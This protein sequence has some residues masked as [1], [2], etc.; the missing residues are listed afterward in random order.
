[1]IF[2]NSP[3]E[4]SFWSGLNGV[5][6]IE[7]ESKVKNKT[8]LSFVDGNFDGLSDS[9]SSSPKQKTPEKRNTKR[10]VRTPTRRYQPLQI[11]IKKSP[12]SKIKNEN[13]KQDD[14]SKLFKQLQ[15]NAAKIIQSVNKNLDNS[16]DFS[17][18]ESRH[19][20]IVVQPNEKDSTTP[21]VFVNMNTPEKVMIKNLQTSSNKYQPLPINVLRS[22]TLNDKS[23]SEVSGTKSTLENDSKLFKPIQKDA[24]K[25]IEVSSKLTDKSCELTVFGNRLKNKTP[26]KKNKNKTIRSPKRKYQPL[27]IT[28]KKSPVS[29]NKEISD[30][31]EKNIEQ[32]SNDAEISNEFS[33]ND[34]E[35]I[36]NSDEMCYGSSQKTPKKS[37]KVKTIRTP[38]RSRQ[39][40]QFCVLKSPAKNIKG[41]LN[42]VDTESLTT[43]KKDAVLFEQLQQSASV[44]NNIIRSPKT[45]PTNSNQTSIQSN[46]Y[47]LRKKQIMENKDKKLNINDNLRINVLKKSKLMEGW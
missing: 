8:G 18:M 20:K 40:M 30:F 44:I 31:M 14:E 27:Q 6:Q 34:D 43:P 24:C 7:R 10:V 16:S 5:S 32:N 39:P 37:E 28:I 13:E 19:D 9:S 23:I 12:S 2:R 15:Q 45:S 17:N 41:I 22:P 35:M 21:S 42:K 47:N 38:A 25:N 1:M 26:E 36:A 3:W 29:K 46:M 11:T 4:E 33:L